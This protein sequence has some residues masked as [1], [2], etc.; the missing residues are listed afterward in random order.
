MALVELSGLI[1][2][3]RGKVKGS[4]IQLSNSGFILRNNAIPANR[5]T[6]LQH[7]TRANTFRILQEWT[8]LSDAQRATWLSYTQYN[9]VPQ[10]RTRYLKLSGQQTFIKF[11]SYRLE[12]DLPI[13]LTPWFNKCIL[14]PISLTLSSTGA[15]LS[16]TA[17]R[18]LV[19]ADEF[20][21]LF[22]TVIYRSS[23]NNPG[24]TYKLIKFVTTNTDTFNITAPYLALFGTI[25]QPGETIFMKYTNA[26]KLSGL[27]FPF[28]FEKVLL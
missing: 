17:N 8:K 5:N 27:P 3:I 2:S 6:N 21:I 12:Y 13:L 16:I 11:N 25:P 24:S 10:K 22:L 15:V 18:V 26:S 7:K 1:T 14:T 19:S 9:P 28:K 4:V 23:V 20:I